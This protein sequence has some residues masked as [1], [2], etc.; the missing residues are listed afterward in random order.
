[1]CLIEIKIPLDFEVKEIKSYVIKQDPITIIDPGPY[2]KEFF[3][4]LKYALK[5]H[6]LIPQD[7][8]RIILTHGH[9]DH[10]GIAGFFQEEFGC[11]V[12]IH[13]NDVEK[14]ATTFD[15]KISKRKSFYIKIFIENGFPDNIVDF[16]INYV[17]G[18]YKFTFKVNRFNK[19]KDEDFIEFEKFKLKVYHF[20][21]HTSG[22]CCF[23]LKDDKF[24]SGDVLLKDVFVTPLLEF[25]KQGNSRKNLKNFLYSLNKLKKFAYLNWYT[26]H[27]EN[28]FDKLLRIEEIK[29]MINSKIEVIR[30]N[31]NFNLTIYENFSNI[32]PNLEIE[33]F[34]F[35]FSFFYGVLE[36]LNVE[37]KFKKI[38]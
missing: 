21:G 24:I 9:A 8:R 26:A 31:L 3:N 22:H 28:N 6:N 1:M 4:Y 29:K 17:S 12:Y 18:F 10:A 20:P 2:S 38:Y 19:I 13:E 16:L 27:G 36:I 14:I 11:E 25:D 33:K 5:K 35:Y 34:L 7:I 32:Y 15:E 30:K 23:L 37:K